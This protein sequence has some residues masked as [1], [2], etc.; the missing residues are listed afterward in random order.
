METR[1]STVGQMILK[2]FVGTWV[3][4]NGFR[5]MPDDPL[6]EFPATATVTVAAGGHLTS[7]VYG[8]QHPADG[9]QDGLIVIGAAGEDGSL[10]AWWGDSWHQQPAPMSLTGGQGAGG[11]V[12]FEGSYWRIAFDSSDAENLRMRMDN[13]ISVGQELPA[14]PYPVMVMHVRRSGT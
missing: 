4:T 9:P 5:F 2:E 12:E 14:G 3:G 8:W 7:V 11:M 10:A 1:A 13:V 6:A